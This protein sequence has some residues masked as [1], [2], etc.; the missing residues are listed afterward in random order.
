VVTWHLPVRVLGTVLLLT[1]IAPRAGAVPDS[2]A[3]VGYLTNE[4]GV[5]LEGTVRA[6]VS[7]FAAPDDED[8]VWGPAD[9][10]DRPVLGGVLVLTL[11]RVP[12]EGIAEVLRAHPHG[13]FLGVTLDD[14]PL[15]PH[16][17]L[18]AVPYAI[19]SGDSERLGGLPAAAYA[20]RD[21]LPDVSDFVTE[22]ELAPVC[23]SNRYEALDGRPDLSGF[24]R[25]GDLPDLSGYVRAGDLPDL[26]GYVR[27][28]DLPAVCASGAYA[29]L[30]GAPDPA[31]F[32][33]RS[34]FDALR[35]RV[36]CHENCAAPASG[37]CRRAVCRAD[38]E[39]CAEEAEQDGTPCDDGAGRCVAGRC[40]RGQ[41][42]GVTCPPLAG[43]RVGCNAQAHCEYVPLDAAADPYRAWIWVPPGSFAMGGP[44]A[45]GGPARER[46]V[47]TVTFAQGYFIARNEI[48]VA[49]YEAC[50]AA[51]ACG[52][53]SARDWNGF[54]WGVN[55][56]A[57][58]RADHPQNGITR[59]D[60]EAFCAWLV[61]GG[62]LPSEA[63]WEYA[64]TG[65]V[66]RT[67]PWGDEPPT[68]QRASFDHDV[69]G[70]LPWGCDACVEW[71][72]SGS[73]PVGSFPAG[74]SWTG[75]LDMGGN[76]WEWTA[77][78]HDT[79]YTATPTDGSAHTATN[80]AVLRGGAYANGPEF[81]RTAHR[82]LHPEA[83]H[84]ADFGARCVWP[85]AQGGAP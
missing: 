74:A 60:A 25:A 18:G 68:C 22:E 33:P 35:Q 63:E 72:C 41:C 77:D 75:A 45:E 65:P 19:L 50:E 47:H 28:A 52:A 42:G 17:P 64:A 73:S 14:V 46:P 29:D 53:P 79:D 40:F 4:D 20:L 58:G 39:A 3:Y 12:A 54:R 2:I 48:V 83:G 81:T 44:E 13:L 24:L 66:H 71:G 56:S 8:P 84:I 1:V 80:A 30:A 11:G 59:P 69:D 49:Q 16:Q 6:V 76:V 51:G 85:A 78:C 7:L 5:A 82:E 27:A 61:P 37:G 34:E 15:T 21:D 36:W 62:R 43:Y 10:G 70:G 55:R 26:S 31:R 38:Q 67:Y 32:V 23:A 9:L 57:D